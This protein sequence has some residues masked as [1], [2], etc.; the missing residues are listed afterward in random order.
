MITPQRL[1]RA[2][3]FT[4]LEMLIVLFITALIMSAMYSVADGTILLADDIQKNQRREHR[5]YAYID[6]CQHLFSDLPAS[7]ALNI[8]TKQDDSGYLSTLEVQNV[9][10]PFDGSPQQIVTLKTV[11]VAGG[12]MRM[13][14]TTQRMPDPQKPT[15]PPGPVMSAVLLDSLIQCEWRAYDVA[16]NQ[17]ASIWREQIPNMLTMPPAP[18]VG[19]PGAAVPVTTA[20]PVMATIRSA[21][22]LM[23]ELTLATGVDHPRRWVFWIPPSVLPTR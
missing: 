5:L 6:Y 11:S 8:Q 21:H 3:G 22:P 4:L 2:R 7:A 15:E 23:L 18:P 9:S 14:I 20:P 1:S 17:W 19:A 16:S 10:S 13:M 12:G